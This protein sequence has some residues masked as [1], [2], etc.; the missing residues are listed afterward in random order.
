MRRNILHAVS[1][2][3]FILTVLISPQ[4]GIDAAPALGQTAA[5]AD[6]RTQEQPPL[7]EDVLQLCPADG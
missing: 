2:A 6:M 7:L 5:A 3:L 4:I 1:A